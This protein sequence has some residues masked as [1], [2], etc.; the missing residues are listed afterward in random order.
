MITFIIILAFVI[1]LVGYSLYDMKKKQK[2]LGDDPNY[3][4]PE[5]EESEE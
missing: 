4:E 1:I 2:K 3:V 5:A